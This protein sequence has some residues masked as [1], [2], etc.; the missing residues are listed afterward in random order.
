MNEVDS[1][2]SLIDATAF[3]FGSGGRLRRTGKNSPP[4]LGE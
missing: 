2:S 4:G 3:A 1:S